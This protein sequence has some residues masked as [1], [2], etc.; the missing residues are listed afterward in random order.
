MK[1][2]WLSCLLALAV[3]EA[4]V[5]PS[6]GGAAAAA[7]SVQARAPQRRDGMRLRADVAGGVAGGVGAVRNLAVTGRV[8]W[9]RLVMNRAQRR[10]FLAILRAE[11][12]AV[13]A[14]LLGLLSLFAERIGGFLYNRFLRR[15]RKDCEYDDSITRLVAGTIEEASRIAVVCYF[16]DVVEVAL[17]VT[18]LK[19]LN[20]DVS[21]LATKLLY[22]TWAAFKLRSY[23]NYVLGL[24]EISKNNER[25]IEIL[26]K[27]SDLLGYGVLALVWID[28]LKINTGKGLQSLLALGSAG[29]LA[30]TLG[31]QDLAKRWLNGLSLAA[32]DAF[33]VGEYIMLGDG[34]NGLVTRLGWLST[35]IR[36]SDEK[37]MRIPNN[38]LSDVRVSNLSRVQFSQVK[39][40]LRFC[41]DDLDKIPALC[42]EIKAEIAASCPKVITD[43]SRAFRVYWVDYAA[44]HVELMVDIRLRNPPSG[45]AYYEARQGVLEAIARAARRKGVEFSRAMEVSL[46]RSAL[47]IGLEEEFKEKEFKEKE[48]KDAA[49]KVV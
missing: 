44:T 13:D 27:V 28:I 32:S 36:A 45:D 18:G 48:F 30:V 6:G 20:F 23:K 47:D 31:C 41:Y 21:I 39:Q 34:T 37:S 38:Q 40:T 33:N 35:D 2:Q 26:E 42:A 49:N 16:F 43:G 19:R 1:W 24:T 25:V 3:A 8:P 5:A 9:S 29:T 10:E 17:E 12:H 46:G 7:R 15:L 14:V 22:A 4:F 11:T